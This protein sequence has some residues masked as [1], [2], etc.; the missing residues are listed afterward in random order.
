MPRHPPAPVA[1]LLVKTAHTLVW[2]LFA[3]AIL[4]LPVASWRGRHALAAGLAA[5]VAAEVLVLL[6]NRMACPLT[7]MAARY[8]E[9]RR[10]NFD[11]FLPLWLARHNKLVFG[12][13][14]LAGL[15]YALLRWCLSPS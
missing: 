11:I 12:L 1:L 5:L 4:A 13:L 3:G 10:D 9:D 2:A 15:G 7:A 8:T 6:L 14:Y